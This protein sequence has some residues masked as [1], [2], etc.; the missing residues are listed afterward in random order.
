MSLPVS[1]VAAYLVVLVWASLPFVPAE[2][3]LVAAGS[4]SATGGLSVLAVVAA[5]AAGSLV[6]DLVKYAIGRL[7]GPALL[8]RL[9]NRPAG[10]RAVTWIEHRVRRIGP[11]VIIPSYFVPVGVVVSTLLCGALRL[12]LRAVVVASAAGAALWAAVFV[13]LGYAG[14]VVS[15][16]PLA[17]IAIGLPAAFLLGALIARRTTARADAG[18]VEDAGSFCRRDRS[19]APSSAVCS[20]QLLDAD[21]DR[22][23]QVYLCVHGRS[24]RCTRAA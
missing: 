5:A 6:S 15:G 18:R 10:A 4:W 17:G 13:L 21:D 1:P 7:A 23:R 2:P 3:M 24:G 22:R 12:P 14:G 11:A 19:T 8:Q 16:H 20:D 9:R